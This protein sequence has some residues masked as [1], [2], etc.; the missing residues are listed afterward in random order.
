MTAQVV[1]IDRSEAADWDE[2]LWQQPAANI[3]ASRSW[4]AYK[5]RLG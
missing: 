3:Y 1:V 4:G 5:G 2:A